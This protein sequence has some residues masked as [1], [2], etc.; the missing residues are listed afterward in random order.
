M[1]KALVILVILSMAAAVCAAGPALAAKK[2]AQQNIV[3]T[4]RPPSPEEEKKIAAQLELT[5]EQ[6]GQMRELSDKYRQQTASLRDKYAAAY[7]DVVNLMQ[8]GNAD[9][10]R[11]DAALRNFHSVHQQFLDTEVEYWMDFKG[12]LTPAQNKTFWGIFS[13]SRIK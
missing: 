5:D 10:G 8:E 13:R 2:G 1:R 4:F 3:V 7:R 9:K 12:I 11:V 6:K